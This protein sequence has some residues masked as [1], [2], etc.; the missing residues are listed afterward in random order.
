[1]NQRFIP[2]ILLIFLFL[3]LAIGSFLANIY[4]NLDM[5]MAESSEK[6]VVRQNI[7][8]DSIKLDDTV[9]L[10]QEY[11]KCGHCIIAPFNDKEDLIGKSLSDLK[12]Q[13]RIENGYQLNYDNNTLVIHQIIDDWCPVDKEKCRLKI[14]KERVAVYKGP[15]TE[16]DVLMRVT[17]IKSDLLPVNIKEAIEKGEYE[18][19]DMERL[20]DALENLDEYL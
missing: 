20:N 17:E 4:S 1:M 3:S 15:N 7:E 18:F 9:I 13:Y 16:Q 12:Q 19:D 5:K 6:P 2:G 11:T 8:N 14:F 10:E